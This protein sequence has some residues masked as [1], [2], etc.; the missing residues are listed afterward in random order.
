MLAKQRGLV[1]VPI[2]ALI[3]LAVVAVVASLLVYLPA[4]AAENPANVIKIMPVRTDVEVNAGQTKTVKT[5]V[6]NL[7]DEPLTLTPV[8]NDFIAGDERGTPALILD[9]DKYAPTH[10]LKRFIQPL[11]DVTIPANE[12][13]AVDVTITVPKDAQAGGYF[14]AVRFAPASPDGG[15]V[16]LNASAASIILVSVPGDTVDRL[17]LTDFDI[18]QNG[19]SSAYFRSPDNLQLSFRFQN[20]GNT[21]AGPFGKISVKSGNNVVYETDFNSDTPRD[22]VLPDSARRWDVPLDSI[23]N[24]GHYTVT[25]TFTYGKNNQTI[26]ATKLFW[27]IPLPILIGAIVVA[28]LLLLLLA[29]IIRRIITRGRRS[30]NSMRFN[31]R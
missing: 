19:Q 8:V 3:G 4:S 18:Q 15:Q 9:S 29:F 25:A 27:V 12:A 2:A 7:T 28:L 11:S 21:Q 14:G 10:S 6:S 26:E 16:N 22:M 20:Q 17:D 13:K 31:R 23:G 30:G 5:T 24:L 1:N